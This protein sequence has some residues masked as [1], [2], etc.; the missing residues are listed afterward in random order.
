M[1]EMLPE[2]ED[3]E[4]QKRQVEAGA[5]V[6]GQSID[7]TILTSIRIDSI[8]EYSPVEVSM[9]CS[10]PFFVESVR[11]VIQVTLGQ[12]GADGQL[13]ASSKDGSFRLQFQTMGWVMETETTFREKDGPSR[14]YGM[15]FFPFVSATLSCRIAASRPMS[16][17]IIDVPD[18]VRFIWYSLEV[19]DL[20]G[21][22]IVD[23]RPRQSFVA[24]RSKYILLWPFQAQYGHEF[25]W[26]LRFGGMLLTR[27][28][29]LPL[30]YGAIALIGVAAASY[31]SVG[32]T[33][34]TV[35]ATWIF[36]LRQWVGLVPPQRNT[37]LGYLFTW[38]GGLLAIW[39]LTWCLASWRALLLLLVY[40]P[41][42]WFIVSEIRLFE[43]KGRLG[44]LDKWWAKR[45]Y[46]TDTRQDVLAI[47][48]DEPTS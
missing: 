10:E 33:I 45:V 2:Y 44:R 30:Y 14:S 3:N 47:T 37:I 39:A 42:A 36:L 25:S 28:L 24:E 5:V 38:G 4:L 27:A 13:L 1:P 19:K 48:P 7:A 43:M 8:Y 35:V 29:Y 15:R 22:S 23:I 40:V 41:L 18:A 16:L 32:L 12:V 31:Q 34:G 6:I 26:S 46:A 20:C 9:S 17:T 11:G 21:T